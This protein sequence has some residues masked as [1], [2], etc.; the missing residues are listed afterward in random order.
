MRLKSNTV[1]TLYTDYSKETTYMIDVSTKKI[2]S[3]PMHKFSARMRRSMF[4][5]TLAVILFS[6]SERAMSALGLYDLSVSGVILLTA[7]GI[8]T[9][10]SFF[11]WIKMKLRPTSPLKVFLKEF[12][13]SE[14]IENRD[15]LMIKG[16]K[17]QNKSILGTIMLGIACLF[18]FLV[19]FTSASFFA[20]YFAFSLL[21][22]FSLGCGGYKN[23]LYIREIAKYCV[24]MGLIEK[25]ELLW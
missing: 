18:S 24:E 1:A 3:R 7:F 22:L 2:Y 25:N 5:T 23:N 20:Y 15:M 13:Q 12:P 6:R 21:I 16:V 14:V 11:L 10:F 9:G 19:F 8:L 17:Q 4:V